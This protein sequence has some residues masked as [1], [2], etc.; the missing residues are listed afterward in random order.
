MMNLLLC[1]LNSYLGRAALSFLPDAEHRV[2]GLVRDIDL[3]KRKVGADLNTTVFSVDLIKKGKA[4]DDLR[5]QG[6]D[7]SI[8]FAQISN[9]KDNLGVQYELLSLRNFIFLSK[10]NGCNRIVY[11]ARARDNGYLKAVE[12]LFVESEVAY[13]ILLKDL[14]VGVG[15]SFERL[16]DEMLKNRLIYLYSKLGN[17]K[18]KPILLSDL[19]SFIKKVNWQDTFICQWIEFGGER[20]MDMNELVRCYITRRG[21]QMDYKVFAVPSKMLVIWFNKLLYGIDSQSHYDYLLG[22]IGGQVTDNTLWQRQVDF[23]TVPIERGL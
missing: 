6:L 4:F 14:A 3:L 13:T 5:I 9:Q 22:I 18:F 12:D 23:A 20:I 11:V 17:V 19:F 15:S 1:G 7:L 21:V 8:Y 16:M 2:F 10:R